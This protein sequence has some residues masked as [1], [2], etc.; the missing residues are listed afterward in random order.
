V[1]TDQQREDDKKTREM[2]RMWEIENE[3]T[4]TKIL[5]FFALIVISVVMPVI[6]VYGMV[7]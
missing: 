1:I 2:R 4:L 7:K 6:M 5:L 3:M